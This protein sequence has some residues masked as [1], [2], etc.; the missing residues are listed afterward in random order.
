MQPAPERHS[1]APYNEI[2]VDLHIHAKYIQPVKYI[3]YLQCIQ[4]K[5]CRQYAQDTESLHYIQYM[6]G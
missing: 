6:L 3:Q 1:G 5:R 2:R 4:Y